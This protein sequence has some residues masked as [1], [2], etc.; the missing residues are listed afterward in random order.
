MHARLV[1][2]C[3]DQNYPGPTG[4]EQSEKLKV[5]LEVHAHTM[6][7]L[8]PLRKCLFPFSFYSSCGVVFTVQEGD[9]SASQRNATTAHNSVTSSKTMSTENRLYSEHGFFGG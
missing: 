1:M 7:M 2:D 6:Q 3:L 8:L 5:D 4:R 9:Q